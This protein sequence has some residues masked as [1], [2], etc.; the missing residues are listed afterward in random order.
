MTDFQ[1]LT[2]TNLDEVLQFMID[3]DISEFGEADTSREDFEEQWDEMDLSKDG[4]IIRDTQGNIIG[5]ACVSGENGRYGIDIYIH[6]QLSPEGLEDELMGRCL[7]RANKLALQ[8]ADEAHLTGYATS[9]NHRLQQVFE[10][11]GF[12]RHTYHYR[13]QVDFSGPIEPPQWPDDFTLSSYKEDDEIEL[14]NLIQSAFTWEGR[15]PI[16]MDA[17]R[18]LIFRGGRFDPEFFVLVRAHG[19][20][21]GAALSYAEESGGWV[22]QLAV[23]KDYQGKG[24][25]SR[26]LRHMFSVF[27]N[28]NLPGVGLG[29]ASLNNNAW[30]FYE[31]VGMYRK[32]EFIEYRKP[33]K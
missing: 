18:N 17:W 24:L 1:T 22:R 31:R 13:M 19:R 5:Y 21:V 2:K 4:W 29:V 23:A 25:G 16:S 12:D 10:K 14:F 6:F 7:E 30:N 8:V 15:D 20:L 33:L 3:C 32:R 28:R 11:N 27:Y 9:V 26:L